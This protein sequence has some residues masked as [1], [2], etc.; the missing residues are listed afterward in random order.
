MISGAELLEARA[1]QKWVLIPSFAIG[2]AGAFAYLFIVGGNRDACI[3]FLDNAT[4]QWGETIFLLFS[5]VVVIP[6]FLA[7]ALVGLRLAA[8]YRVRCPECEADLLESHDFSVA[9]GLCPRCDARVVEGPEQ[10]T[11]EEWRENARNEE[12]RSAILLPWMFPLCEAVMLGRAMFRD[13]R[14]Y[15]A[16]VY[17]ICGVIVAAYLW[18][19][20]RNRRCAY[21]LCVSAVLIGVWWWLAAR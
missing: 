20:T 11:L 12:L 10:V 14:E 18:L 8:P 4:G 2:I 16:P 3:A 21:S 13:E 17:G 1:R 7:P 9:T 5:P 6:I 19:R 15:L